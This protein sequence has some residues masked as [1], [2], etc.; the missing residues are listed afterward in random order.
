MKISEL[1]EMRSTVRTATNGTDAAAEIRSKLKVKVKV[2]ARAQSKKTGSAKMYFIVT[3]EV[4]REAMKKI[5]LKHGL[6]FAIMG[7]GIDDNEIPYT[8]FSVFVPRDAEVAA[9]KAKA[10]K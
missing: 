1:F 6:E 10:A 8:K 2:D 4:D 7:S 5:L 3:G 9:V